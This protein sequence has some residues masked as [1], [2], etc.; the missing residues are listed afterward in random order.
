MEVMRIVT[1]ALPLF[2]YLS[3]YLIMFKFVNI[4][5]LYAVFMTMYGVQFMIT[6]AKLLKINFYEKVYRRADELTRFY[7]CDASNRERTMF[8]AVGIFFWSF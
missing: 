8:Q 4:L 1:R 2:C 7:T 5:V 6:Q 3:L